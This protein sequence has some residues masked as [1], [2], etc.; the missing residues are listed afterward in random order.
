MTQEQLAD[1]M[2]V[3]RQA[4]SKWES[5][6]A[7]PETD[8]LVRLGELFDCSID[9]LLRE[10][11]QR[12]G[13]KKEEN[14][15]VRTLHVSVPFFSKSYEYVSQRRIG[16][17][18]LVHVNIGRGRVARGVIAVG[19]RSV[20]VLSVG[21][22]SAGIMAF[23]LLSLGVLAFG[24]LSLGIAAFGSIAA[25]VFS[26][27]A[28]ALGALL[29]MGGVAVGSFACGGVAI[30]NYYAWGG[31]ASAKVAIGLTHVKGS[32]WS[33]CGEAL[34]F[35]RT[36]MIQKLKDVTPEALRWIGELVTRFA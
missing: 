33:Y 28:I 3:S 25:G 14:A 36:Q 16:N 6:L 8:K 15:D 1:L 5:D 22:L 12:D 21:L 20:G 27:G 9:Y 26:F 17:L 24:V 30:G 18:P 29:A 34:D 23:G 32:V 35:D 11:T 2:Q 7:F 13:T 31:Y 19:F 4:V 10:N